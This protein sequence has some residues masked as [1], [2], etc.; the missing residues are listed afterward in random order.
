MI[1]P[2]L[3]YNTEVWGAYAKSDL[4]SWDS[5]QIEKTHLQFCKRYLEVSN[6]AS[7]I[8][9]RAELGR[10]PL[11]IAINQKIMN[12]SSYLL[13]K[14]NC[15]IVKQIFLMSQDLHHAGKNS[16]YSNIID[17]S[18]YYNLPCFDIPNLTNAKVKHFV[19]VMQQKYILYRQHTMQNSSK[20]E[21]YNTF[22]T[23]CT[24]SYYLGLTRKL[25]ERKQ[26]VKFRLGNHKLRIETGRYDQ[27]P[28]V[29]RL[30][31]LCKSNQIEDESHFLIYCNKYSILRN[32]FCK[33]N[34]TYH[35]E[36]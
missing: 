29:N 27:I 31:P 15:S 11:I 33:K 35:S 10:F 4:K 8:A 16:Y 17:M 14:D 34:R 36:F 22:K 2:I 23:D 20:L 12:Y 25:N 24:P 1:S 13:S 32:E 19:S 6:R 7:N 26:L 21:F 28:R 3:T 30:Y 9:C 5:S 18:E